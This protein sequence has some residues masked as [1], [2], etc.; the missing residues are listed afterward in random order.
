[1]VPDRPQPMMN[2]GLNSCYEMHSGLFSKVTG[3]NTLELLFAL[4]LIYKK[5]GSYVSQGVF[6]LFI[7]RKL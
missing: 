1:M 4:L 2:I 3:L 7:I 6:R 5:N